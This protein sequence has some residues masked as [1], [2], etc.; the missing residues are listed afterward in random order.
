MLASS[1]VIVSPRGYLHVPDQGHL[2]GSTHANLVISG[3][4]AR[5]PTIRQL[6]IVLGDCRLPTC[7]A[8]TMHDTFHEF[9]ASA[10]VCASVDATGSP[11]V[12]SAIVRL[13][14]L[15]GAGCPVDDIA[16]GTFTW[17]NGYPLYAQPVPSYPEPVF[18]A[19]F[20]AL[21]LHFPVLDDVSFP[22]AVSA[23]ALTA[24]PAEL[25]GLPSPAEV[26][27]PLSPV[28]NQCS[29]T[30]SYTYEASSPTESS[31]SSSPSPSPTVAHPRLPGHHEFVRFQQPLDALVEGWTPVE[32]EA[33]RRLVQFSILQGPGHCRTVRCRVVP[34]SS[35]VSAAGMTSIVSCLAGPQGGFL[36]TSVDLLRLAALLYGDTPRTE[37]KNRLRRHLERFGP[38]T[39]GRQKDVGGLYTRIAT[40]DEPSPLTINKDIK[41][42]KWAR[43]EDAM[44]AIIAK[45]VTYRAPKASKAS[46]SPFPRP[47]L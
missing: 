5:H 14:L 26:S 3:W 38:R 41:I 21:E 47:R 4:A 11:A 34:P 7:V 36:I 18:P 22:S 27:L 10:S 33:G 16:I 28:S 9:T 29:P 1:S 24:S 2:S 25:M 20:N 31:Y 23:E 32:R 37:E 15:D 42:F 45:R 8:C 40:Y 6:R 44:D 39:I 35:R 30:L 12:D 17:T 19:D 13:E 46:A 43:L